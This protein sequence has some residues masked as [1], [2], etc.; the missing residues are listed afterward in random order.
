MLPVHQVHLNFSCQV[1]C[2]MTE[3]K[4][5]L[6]KEILTLHG[7]RELL[8][9]FEQGRLLAYASLPYTRKVACFFQIGIM[10]SSI[11]SSRV[12][13]GLWIQQPL[14]A[15]HFLSPVETLTAVCQ[16]C[17]F[18]IVEY[19]Y[20]NPFFRLCVCVFSRLFGLE[21]VKCPETTGTSQDIV[22]L[23][24]G[25]LVVLQTLNFIAEIQSLPQS[26][27]V[28]HSDG[29]ES[30]QS[31]LLGKLIYIYVCSYRFR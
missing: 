18:V 12:I 11:Y 23:D 26:W 22:L 6:L 21:V 16:V 14:H 29:H 1:N 24:H 8:F 15:Y 2:S 7:S 28:Y 27:T 5:V 31:S 9:L 25:W 20:S 17:I 13:S 19:S 3:I 4:N 30:M 10:P